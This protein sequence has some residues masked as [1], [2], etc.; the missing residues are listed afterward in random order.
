[1]QTESQVARIFLSDLFCVFGVISTYSVPTNLFPASDPAVC[2][3]DGVSALTMLK[4]QTKW[5][6]VFPTHFL[7]NPS[8][9]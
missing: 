8:W 7:S 2:R 1:M 6:L 9:F 3:F 5:Q 4:T